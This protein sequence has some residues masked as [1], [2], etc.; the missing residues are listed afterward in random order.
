[1]PEQDLPKMAKI[2]V[3]AKSKQNFSVILA[4]KNG[5]SI[6]LQTRILIFLLLNT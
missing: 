6:D 3:F 4:D 1:M 5:I 2:P